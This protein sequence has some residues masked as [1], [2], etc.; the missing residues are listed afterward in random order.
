ML[1]SSLCVM[2]VMLTSPL[3]ESTQATIEVEVPPHTQVAMLPLLA[4]LYDGLIDLDM[5]N[6]QPA[7]AV[8]M[9]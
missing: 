7:H 6:I 2:Q 3:R 9:W 8:A 5:P 4:Y 1:F